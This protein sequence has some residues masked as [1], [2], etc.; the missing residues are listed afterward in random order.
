MTPKEQKLKE[1]LS[2]DDNIFEVI[3]SAPQTYNSFLKEFKDNGTYQ[4]I[5]RRRIRRL[6]KEGKL[7]KLSVPGTR[8]GLALF[9]T[10][11]RK[12]KILVSQG[13]MK[14]R[15]FY[16]Y[17]LIDD[18]KHIILENYWELKDPNWS[19]WEYSDEILEIPKYVLRD[20]GF[21]LWD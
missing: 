6:L 10:P 19:K 18:D 2:D 16:F 20:G 4:Q 13:L 11:E 15:I 3:K 1:I 14:V 12:Y 21:R 5:L 17:E 9:C 7:W 8:F